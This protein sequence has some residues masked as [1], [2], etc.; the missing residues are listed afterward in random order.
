MAEVLRQLDEKD[1]E[2]LAK[3]LTDEQAA[4]FRLAVKLI[5]QDPHRPIEAALPETLD[6]LWT[7]GLEELVKQELERLK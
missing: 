4:C 2:V 1:A 6:A 5:Q 3:S 7:M